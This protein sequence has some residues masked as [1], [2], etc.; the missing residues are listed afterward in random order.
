[1]TTLLAAD[2]ELVVADL[3]ARLDLAAKVRLVQG[4][5]T[6]RTFGAPD[7]GMRQIV[8]SDGPVGV[9]G[10]SWDERNVGVNLPCPTALAATWDED[11]VTLLGE[12][13]A[14]ECRL[15]QVDMVLAPDVSDGSGGAEVA[16]RPHQGGE[17][18]AEQCGHV[19]PNTRMGSGSTGDAPD[20]LREATGWSSLGTSA[21]VRGRVAGSGHGG[22]FPLL[23]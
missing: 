15:K 8:M 4:Q 5:T 18:A 11:L 16:A 6:W 21:P 12:L 7:A 22:I 13:L 20:P 2:H 1:M 9:R 17:H 14:G 19:T 3:L 23:L 10:E